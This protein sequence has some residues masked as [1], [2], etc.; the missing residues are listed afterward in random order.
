MYD[1]RHGSVGPSALAL[2]H[3]LKGMK[4]KG[5]NTGWGPRSSVLIS[6]TTREEV[7]SHTRK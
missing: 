6:F 1:L 7:M 3:I 4:R 2:N 5:K